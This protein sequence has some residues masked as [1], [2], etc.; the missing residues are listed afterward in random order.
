MNAYFMA[1]GDPRR[2]PTLFLGSLGLGEAGHFPAANAAAPQAPAAGG[3]CQ[4]TPP[5]PPCPSPAPAPHANDGS[6][7]GPAPSPE[8]P[9]RSAGPPR[10]PSAPP[11]LRTL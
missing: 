6:A 5:R 11:E 3:P 10:L 1:G 8:P 9:P 4:E 2:S 7:S